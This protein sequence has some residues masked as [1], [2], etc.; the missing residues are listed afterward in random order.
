MQMYSEDEIKQATPWSKTQNLMLVMAP[1]VTT[2]GL[3]AGA[4]VRVRISTGRRASQAPDHLGDRHGDGRGQ[5]EVDG[6][7]HLAAEVAAGD[8]TGGSTPGAEADAPAVG[9]AVGHVGHR[10][11]R[12]P[13]RRV[14][15][16]R[17]G[18]AQ[19]RHEHLRRLVLALLPHDEEDG[20]GLQERRDGGGAHEEDEGRE[21]AVGDSPRPRTVRRVHGALAR[22]GHQ[23]RRRHR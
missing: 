4:G 13:G 16:R 18:D 3:G 11:E 22:R 1:M 10:R 14:E 21:V 20:D 9:G 15:Q 7:M 17:H 6:D 23:H 19:Q 2:A 12:G 5:R 8:T